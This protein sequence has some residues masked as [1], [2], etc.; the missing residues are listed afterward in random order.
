[1][2]VYT[3]HLFGDFDG[4]RGALLDSLECLCPL[5]DGLDVVSAVEGVKLFEFV[6]KSVPVREM[7]R[8]AFGRQDRLTRRDEDFEDVVVTSE[9]VARM[10][11]LGYGAVRGRAVEGEVG[12]GV[13]LHRGADAGVERRVI[14]EQE[15]GVGCLVMQ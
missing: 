4:P 13:L 12:I 9:G 14:D 11:P 7:L 6:P 3:V 5:R 2:T 15:A 8:A 1:M 10:A